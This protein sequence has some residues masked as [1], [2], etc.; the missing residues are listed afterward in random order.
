[1]FFAY[2]NQK[3]ISSGM[4]KEKEF[5]RKNKK[6]FQSTN[7][8]LLIPVTSDLTINEYSE[9]LLKAQGLTDT[10]ISGS[11][12]AK[13][14]HTSAEVLSLLPGLGRSPGEG[15]GNP[16]LYSYLE[17]PMDGGTWLGYSQWGRKESDTTE[18]LH[19]LKSLFSFSLRYSPSLCPLPLAS[20]FLRCT[21]NLQIPSAKSN[22]KF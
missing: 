6:S 7:I 16:L 1:M 5:M 3:F 14:S 19:S 8:L 18:Q 4:I 17:N 20:Q 15:N 11:S 21:V 12:A 2:L 22:T 10:E 9:L 13:N